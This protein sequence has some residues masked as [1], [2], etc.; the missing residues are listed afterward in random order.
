MSIR[1]DD[2]K[3]RLRLFATKKEAMAYPNAKNLTYYAGGILVQNENDRWV[4]TDGLLPEGWEP[5]P[6]NIF[7]NIDVER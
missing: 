1:F 7:M 3:V 6:H 4:D 5:S 2:G